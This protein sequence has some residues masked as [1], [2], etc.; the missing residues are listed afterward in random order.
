M[1]PALASMSSFSILLQP[2]LSMVAFMLWLGLMVAVL[3]NS[4]L[5]ALRLQTATLL[6]GLYVATEF[7]NL[8][9]W[10]GSYMAATTLARMGVLTQ[11]KQWCINAKNFLGLD[12]MLGDVLAAFW[13]SV[14][15]LIMPTL[16]W[17]LGVNFLPE[18]VSRT[19]FVASWAQKMSTNTW[20]F[21]VWYPL[22]LSGALVVRI[23]LSVMLG[24]AALFVFLGSTEFIEDELK[25]VMTCWLALQRGIRRALPLF[26]VSASMNWCLLSFAHPI[27]SAITAAALV[28][29]ATSVFLYGVT[30]LTGTLGNLKLILELCGS[31]NQQMFEWLDMQVSTLLWPVLSVQAQMANEIGHCN[32]KQLNTLKK[33]FKAGLAFG[34]FLALL[35]IVQWLSGSQHLVVIVPFMLAC[36]LGIAGR[37]TVVNK[38]GALSRIGSF[39]LGTLCAQSAACLLTGRM[40]GLYIGFG[41]TPFTIL[42]M[43]F[44]K[45]IW[46]WLASILVVGLAV[47]CVG[48]LQ[49]RL[50]LLR[51]WW[52]KKGGHEAQSLD[53]P[54]DIDELCLASLQSISDDHSTFR[55]KFTTPC[56]FDLD[57]F[58]SGGLSKEWATLFAQGITQGSKHIMWSFF[59][60]WDSDSGFFHL[61]Y[62]AI[63]V[64][65]MKETAAAVDGA[66]FQDFALSVEDLF[67]R[68]GVVMAKC[69]LRN[70]Q[71]IPLSG[72]LVKFVIRS[73]QDS[74]WKYSITYAD[75][76]ELCPSYAKHMRTSPEFTPFEEIPLPTEFVSTIDIPTSFQD[77]D[78]NPQKQPTEQQWDS[79][80]AEILENHHVLPLLESFKLG[81]R[82]VIDMNL[83]ELFSVAEV[84]Q[85]MQGS[86]SISLDD[87]RTHTF[88]AECAADHPV[89]EALWKEMER[90]SQQQLQM[91]CKY[92]TGSK[93]APMGGFSA[94]I[95]R[96]TVRVTG[97]VTAIN[98]HTCFNILDLPEAMDVAM[99]TT[100]LMN[101][102]REDGVGSLG[103]VG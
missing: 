77:G 64:E 91:L 34:G 40:A 53:V 44:V 79:L 33:L 70:V 45:A 48:P 52:V 65:Q 31:N 16:V 22:A 39:S 97:T 29:I 73:D 60:K 9:L 87:W 98:A 5:R 32:D 93:T 82:K 36:F 43:I 41:L 66:P 103:S 37:F 74:D 38:K 63:T 30:H 102:C 54:Y 68:L 7:P 94:L 61:N 27:V 42:A 85:L 4:P 46:L 76:E 21:F 75:F 26:L 19:A 100:T 55:V 59:R 28:G 62:E 3:S 12:A 90:L 51:V 25:N 56:P 89:I 6:A 88:Y 18:A 71:L 13:K 17:C 58:D 101:V 35:S 15:P 14:G 1:Y 49:F 8:Y 11:A 10:C 20:L 47:V 50:F 2:T 96:F 92:V 72:A 78:F 69:F 23:T 81:F 95:P 84:Q 83:G 57:Q 67:C 80:A 86:A 24:I 99:M